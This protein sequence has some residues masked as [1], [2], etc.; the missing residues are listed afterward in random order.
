MKIQVA[1][2]L[3]AIACLSASLYT[4]L[5]MRPGVRILGVQIQRYFWV[6][7]SS[8]AWALGWWLWLIS[9]FCWMLLMVTLAWS[10]IP[11]HRVPSMLQSGLMI[12]AATLGIGGIVVWMNALPL[13]AALENAHAIAPLVD[14]VSLGLM[15]SGLFMGGIVT[16]WMGFDLW[17]LNILPFRWVLPMMVAGLSALPSPFL[18]PQATHL[19]VGLT[20]WLGWC[21]FLATRHQFPLSFKEWL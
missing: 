14:A 20:I 4:F 8:G 9:I 21:V 1:A 5:V 16:A 15:G 2:T 18:F 19:I 6:S 3:S 10:Y 12:I 7:E 17:R 13:A 11:A